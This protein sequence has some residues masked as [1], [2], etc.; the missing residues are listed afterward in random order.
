MLLAPVAAALLFPA[1]LT[2]HG[3]EISI[4]TGM[5]RFQTETVR[6]MYSTGEEM[7]Y[8]RI[9]VYAPSNPETEIVQ[10]ITDRNGYYSFVPD[11]EGEWRLT[12]EDDMGHKGEIRVIA[13]SAGNRAVTVP[14]RTTP[15]GLRIIFGLSLILNIFAVYHFVLGRGLKV[16]G[17]QPKP[18]PPKGGEHA[19]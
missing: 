1:L 7:S 14:S 3:V 10:S 6:F 13:S 8:A 16:L 19:Y 9:R 15:L 5:T 11:D 12:V 2:A 17:K 4:A 18:G